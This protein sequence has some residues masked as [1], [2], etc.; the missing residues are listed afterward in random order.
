MKN[1]VA[2]KWKRVYM[3]ALKE[4]KLA[5]KI[6]KEAQ[7]A[8][9]TYF[10]EQNKA[11]IIKHI[12]EG[13]RT[14]MNALSNKIKQGVSNYPIIRQ[15]LSC[16]VTL[17]KSGIMIT[18]SLENSNVS[19]MVEILKQT[20]NKASL[21]T[22]NN[23]FSEA[24]KSKI[25]LYDTNNNPGKAV[26]AVDLIVD[27]WRTMGYWEYLT[28][29]IFF[30]NIL[31]GTLE[32]GSELRQKCVFEVNDFLNKRESGDIRDD[33]TQV[34]EGGFG[35]MPCYR[36]L[37]EYIKQQQ[38]SGRYRS[39]NAGE[40]TKKSDNGT[41]SSNSNN[42]NK[43]NNYDCK[44]P[45]KTKI[46]NTEQAAVASVISKAKT[47]YNGEVLYED[48][49]KVTD[50][51]TGFEYKYTATKAEC[52]LCA[53]KD[54]GSSHMPRCYKGQCRKCGHYGHKH[55]S[56]LQDPASYVPSVKGRV[57]TAYSS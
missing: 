26:Q 34:S 5:T 8:R 2:N 15:K 37:S 44:Y 40:V 53:G 11:V 51:S 24:L 38:E 39:H 12:I 19:G 18:N 23:D 1:L 25:S 36:F 22:F 42:Y 41:H 3:N 27:M 9:D 17:E 30:V 50:M 16:V 54:A 32:G 49:V 6:A 47:V 35:S 29:D 13:L 57:G 4:H 46:G 20:Y 14:G 45:S 21:V 31:L 52:P 7:E 33:M 48:N 56:C 55:S 43:N 10:K 28:K